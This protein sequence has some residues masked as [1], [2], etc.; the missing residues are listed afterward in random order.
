MIKLFDTGEE[1]KNNS[2]SKKIGIASGNHSI[3]NSHENSQN[4]RNI[5]DNFNDEEQYSLKK[6]LDPITKS[7]GLMTKLDNQTVAESPAGY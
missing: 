2:V 7:F 5:A 6:K 4:S 3:K 1:S